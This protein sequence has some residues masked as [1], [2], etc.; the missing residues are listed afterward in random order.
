MVEVVVGDDTLCI[1]HGDLEGVGVLQTAAVGV[2]VAVVESDWLFEL[3][4][5]NMSTMKHNTVVGKQ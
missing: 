5:K 3:K 2:R 1:S 4:T